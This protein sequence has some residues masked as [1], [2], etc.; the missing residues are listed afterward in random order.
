[1]NWLDY[2]MVFT[3][4]IAVIILA[5]GFMLTLSEDRGWKS[6]VD[7]LQHAVKPRPFIQRMP[8]PTWLRA[9]TLLDILFAPLWYALW[10]A[11]SIVAAC[12]ALWDGGLKETIKVILGGPIGPG[13]YGILRQASIKLYKRTDACHIRV[14]A[15]NK[16]KAEHW[17][18]VK[19]EPV[20]YYD[21][22]D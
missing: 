18:S 14:D 9:I 22:E 6:W 13:Y 8:E 2:F 4:S 5:W 21:K 1:M 3:G 12:F 15:W 7:D 17:K 20:Y 10:W 19:V 16:A 11:I